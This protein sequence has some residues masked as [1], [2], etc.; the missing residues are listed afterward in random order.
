MVQK[1]SQNGPKEVP[2]TLKSR[3]TAGSKKGS[4]SEPSLE[5]LLDASECLK[6]CFWPKIVFSG[7]KRGTRIDE[8]SFKNRNVFRVAFGIASRRS[9]D[10]FSS[11]IGNSKTFQSVVLS[12]IFTLSAHPNKHR[13]PTSFPSDLGAILDLQKDPKT[14]PKPM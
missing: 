1:C 8:K 10:R 13:F 5:S 11:W 14:H 6:N 3:K 7:P 9:F 2:K 12:L 4:V